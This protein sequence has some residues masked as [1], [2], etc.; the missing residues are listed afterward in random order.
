MAKFLVTGSVAGKNG[1]RPFEKLLEAQS[2]K[3]AREKA[4]ALLG[5]NAGIKRSAIKIDSV[6]KA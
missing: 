3:L 5:S 6:E 1:R 4:M 2:E